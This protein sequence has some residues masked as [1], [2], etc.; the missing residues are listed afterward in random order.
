MADASLALVAYAVA[1]IVIVIAA[2]RLAIRKNSAAGSIPSL[3]FGASVVVFSIL[4]ITNPMTGEVSDLMKLITVWAFS[5]AIAN[6]RTGSQGLRR[7]AKW[8]ALLL[9]LILSAAGA[10]QVM[11]YWE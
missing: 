7:A 8:W 9:T 5:V 11:V 3:L 4:G 6:G 2:A 10:Y 1:G